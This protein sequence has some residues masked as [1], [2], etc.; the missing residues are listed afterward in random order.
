HS[1][2][3]LFSLRGWRGVNIEPN[4]HF[5]RLLC[6]SRPRDVNLQAAVSDRS[7]KAKYYEVIDSLTESTLSPDRARA[8]RDS[9]RPVREEEIDTLPMAE[10]LHRHVGDRP[11]DFMSIDVEGHERAVLSTADFTRWRP[12][13]LIVE[14]TEPNTNVPNH[15][16][17]EDLVTAAGYLF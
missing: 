2:T 3:K 4:P 15:Q 6:Q 7:G 1:T 9:G 13:V 5:F 10:I 14:A 17:W 11:I 8:V 16:K 12:R